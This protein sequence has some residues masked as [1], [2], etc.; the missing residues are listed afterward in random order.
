VGRPPVELGPGGGGGVVGRGL[1]CE[2]AGAVG[3]PLARAAG[4]GVARGGDVL[5]DAAA[6]EAHGVGLWVWVIATC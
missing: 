3:A 6:D 4:G 1:D 2:A 5:G